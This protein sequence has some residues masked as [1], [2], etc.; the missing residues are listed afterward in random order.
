[1]I[2]NKTPTMSSFKPLNLETIYFCISFYL[3]PDI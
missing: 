2:Q 1:M 3:N